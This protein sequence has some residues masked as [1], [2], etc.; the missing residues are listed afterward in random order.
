MARNI[1]QSALDKRPK[2]TIM[3][4]EIEERRRT[5][6]YLLREIHNIARRGLTRIETDPENDGTIVPAGTRV[7]NNIAKL[8]YSTEDVHRCLLALKDS[9]FCHCERYVGFSKWFDVYRCTYISPADQKPD[10]LYVK[11]RLAQNRGR[12]ALVIVLSSFDR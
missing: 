8:G 11:L 12:G 5:A 9:D 1:A 6:Q 10:D 3:V 2:L 4:N 7:A